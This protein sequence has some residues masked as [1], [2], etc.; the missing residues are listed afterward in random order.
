MVLT[1]PPPRTN[2]A[3]TLSTSDTAYKKAR[4][5]FLKSTRNRPKDIE[6]QWTPFRNAEK[7]FKA[8]FPP[9]DLSAVLD[10]ALLDET[11]NT[12]VINSGYKGGLEEIGV[13]WKEI[14]FGESQGLL[15]RRRKKAYL[16]PRIPGGWNFSVSV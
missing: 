14:E 13:K 7:K 8:K 16:L 15:G 1:S 5:Q 11:R 12:E 6:D 2:T 3:A 4:R 9:P 10:L